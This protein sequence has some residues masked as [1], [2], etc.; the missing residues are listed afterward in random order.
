M[1]IDPLMFK[2]ESFERLEYKGGV[3][4][5]ELLYVTVARHDRNDVVTLTNKIHS[6]LRLLIRS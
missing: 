3:K 1:R 2:L 5:R 6:F 4:E